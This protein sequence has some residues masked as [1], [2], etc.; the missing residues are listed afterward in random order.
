MMTRFNKDMY[1]K[2]RSKKDEPLANIGKEGVRIMGK[3]PSVR[4][5]FRRCHSHRLESR[6]STGGFVGHFS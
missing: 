5:S 3:G 2:M 1:A 6:E 4:P